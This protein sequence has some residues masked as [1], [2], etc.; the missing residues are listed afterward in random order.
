VQAPGFI[1]PEKSAILH[2]FIHFP[3]VTMA[4]SAV[5]HYI[6]DPLCGWCYGAAP[7]VDAALAVPGLQVVPHAGGM[8]A[9]AQRQRVSAQWRSY[10]MPHDRRI[11]QVSGQP[12]GDAYFDGLLND[13]SAW[14]DSA[15]P[16]TG[17]LAAMQ[18]R[19]G[20]PAAGIAFVKQVQQAHYRDGRR[21]A[22]TEVLVAIA[23]ALGHAEEPFRAA[24]AALAGAP[25][26]QHIAH[27]RALL[28]QVGG[29][30]F[31][32]FVL[33]TGG[34]A[35]LLP[36]GQYIGQPQAFAQALQSQVVAAGV[37][38]ELGSADPLGC[39]PDACAI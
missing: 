32:T 26:E 18:L 5:L 16:I 19:Q 22:D 10:V 36:L 25:T 17:M 23:Q 37:A 9:G 7:L 28:Q 38:P 14:M 30:G 8:L 20:D 15:P 13:T 24:L 1:A 4:P 6:H 35:Q 11:A 34:R 31:P 21:I 2:G 12:F 33:Q 3:F 29:A 27:S 39:G